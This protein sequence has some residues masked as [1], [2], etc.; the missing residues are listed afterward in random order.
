[1][2]PFTSCRNLFFTSIAFVVPCMIFLFCFGRGI[3]YC[4]NLNLDNARTGFKQLFFC[5]TVSH[6]RFA[7]LKMFS[8]EFSWAIPRTANLGKS[9][10]FVLVFTDH[11]CSLPF[12]FSTSRIPFLWL[13]IYGSTLYPEINPIDLPFGHISHV[14]SVFYLLG[15]ILNIKYKF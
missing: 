2:G 15:T 8:K 14:T 12:E 6:S 5:L 10:D 4:H 11:V 7:L 13:V 3:F 9:R 1:M